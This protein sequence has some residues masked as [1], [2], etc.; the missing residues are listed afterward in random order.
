MN[1]RVV[2]VR[3]VCLCDSIRLPD[4]GIVLRKGESTTLSEA[5]AESSRDLKKAARIRAVKMTRILGPRTVRPQKPKAADRAPE[6]RARPAPPLDPAALLRAAA[7]AAMSGHMETLSNRL[8][9]AAAAAADKAMG[10]VVEALSQMKVQGDAPAAPTPPVD[11]EWFEAA[12][13]TAL[14]SV[15][16]APG[17][18]PGPD[19]DMPMFIPSGMADGIEGEVGTVEGSSTGSGVDEAT[20]ALKALRRKKRDAKDG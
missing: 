7:E 9:A 18:R 5:A 16:A 8:D 11:R 15:G 14:S 19:G 12:L 1:S 20:E 13:R 17:Q 6:L 2:S 3:V 10:R 4:L